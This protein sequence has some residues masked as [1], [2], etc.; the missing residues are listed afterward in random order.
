M[1][2]QKCFKEE[3]F[4]ILQRQWYKVLLDNNLT[5]ITVNSA[6][7]ANMLLLDK[8]TWYKK[9]NTRNHKDKLVEDSFT[10]VDCL[11]LFKLQTK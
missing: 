4:S 10:I 7:D 11:I 6:L 3:E 2:Q 1:H 8:T 9:K 5:S